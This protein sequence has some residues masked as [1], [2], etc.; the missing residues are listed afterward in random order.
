[1]LSSANEGPSTTAKKQI[2]VEEVKIVSPRAPSVRAKYRISNCTTRDGTSTTDNTMWKS[3]SA[4]T[5]FGTMPS[6]TITFVP[7]APMNDHL[8]G[9]TRKSDK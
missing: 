6:S 8:G 4:M 1:M 5:H 9:T 7:P 3:I 2:R